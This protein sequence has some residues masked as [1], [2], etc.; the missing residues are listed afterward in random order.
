MLCTG[1][2]V[3]WWDV[4]PA[5]ASHHQTLKLILSGPSLSSARISPPSTYR[6]KEED[7]KRQGYE[8]VHGVR[9]AP[10]A[11]HHAAAAIKKAFHSH[12]QKVARDRFE[13]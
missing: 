13:A 10:S 12:H 8:Q 1:T 9:L 11:P 4:T 5:F 3:W 7:R 2:G 6:V